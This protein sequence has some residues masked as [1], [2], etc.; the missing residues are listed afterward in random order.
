[1][2]KNRSTS[3][4]KIPS[5][6][7]FFAEQGRSG[8]RKAFTL[9]ELLVVIA[10]IAILACLLLPALSSAKASARR[11]HCLNNLK[12]LALTWTLYADENNDRL[13]PNG[14]GIPDVLG[15]TKLWVVGGTHWALPEYQQVFTNVDYLVNPAYAAFA[16]YLPTPAIYK[17]PADRG[18]VAIGEKEYPRVRSYSL[19]NFMGW[20]KPTNS[21]NSAAFVTFQ[22]S[23]EVSAA[24]KP[25]ELL[26]FLDVAPPSICHSAF[27]VHMGMNY[28]HFPS[29]EHNRSGVVSFADGHVETH[30]WT[31]AYTMEMGRTTFT[32]HFNFLFNS[33]PDLAWLQAR[34]SV[35]RASP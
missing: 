30:R 10:I 18:K 26:L 19:N 21:E 14:Y 27:V 31:D 5:C 11:T 33:N 22:K 13:A 17:C 20:Q 34:A 6:P 25:S 16:N 1:M 23:S 12:Q 24:E 7:A 28:Y 2:N 29:S 4:R 35:R 9:I 15:D 8:L 3:R 32:T